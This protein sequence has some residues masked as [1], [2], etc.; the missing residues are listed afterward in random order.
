MNLK[1][2]ALI[3]FGLAY[4][5]ATYAQQKDRQHTGFFLSLSLGPIFG[6]IHM[7]SS[8]DGKYD[9]TG[10]GASFDIKIGGAIQENLILHATLNA[11]SIVGPK[12]EL[13]N[14]QSYKNT[15]NVTFGEALLGG[16]LTYYFMPSNIFISGSAGLANFSVDNQDINYKSTT[17]RGFGF[18]LKAGK[19]WWVSKR[20]GLGISGTYGRS[21]VDSKPGNGLREQLSS[22]RFGISF[23]ATLN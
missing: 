4:S 6:P 21:S 3:A 14:G 16:G 10:T 18:Q 11:N 9:L 8:V 7:D 13:P 22:D 2:I 19:E 17:D 20:W 15:N 23:N 1:K 12:Q 5:V